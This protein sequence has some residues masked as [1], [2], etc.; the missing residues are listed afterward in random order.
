MKFIL[1]LTQVDKEDID[2]AGAKAV[3]LGESL[4][5][6]LKIPQGFV[7]TSEAFRNFISQNNLAESVKALAAELATGS[8]SMRQEVFENLRKIIL[9]QDFSTELATEI[10]KSV[11]K[12]SAKDTLLLVSSSPNKRTS[13]ESFGDTV[14]VNNEKELPRRLRSIG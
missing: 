6:G 14:V 3:S 1:N 9:S 5:I 7:I 2:V 10:K 12:I 13:S 8:A 4:K 11:E